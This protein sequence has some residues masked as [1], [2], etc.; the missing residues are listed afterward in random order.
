LNR[1]VALPDFKF[2]MQHPC[3]IRAAQHELAVGLV[4]S[5]VRMSAVPFWQQ[6]LQLGRAGRPVAQPLK[7]DSLGRA[8]SEAV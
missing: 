2:E 5:L 4:N 3:D 6:A 7:P 1:G 8:R